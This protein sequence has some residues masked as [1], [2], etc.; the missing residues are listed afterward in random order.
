[1]TG[2]LIELAMA[3]GI[4]ALP[5]VVAAGLFAPGTRRAALALAPWVPVTALALVAGLYGRVVEMPWLLLGARVG[6]DALTAPLLLLAGVAWTL[7]GWHAHHHIDAVARKRFFLFWLLTWMGNLCVFITLDA[8]SFYAAYA[9]MTFAAYG[10]V[11]FHGRPQD[12]HAGGIYIIMA[13]LGEA[14]IIAALLTLGGSFGNIP[15]EQGGALVAQLPQPHWVTG[16]FLAGF[17]VKAGVVPLHMW[18]ALAH[19][20][21]PVPAS[22]V[23]SGVILKA[24]LM[25]WLRF[26]P[27][28]AE[29]FQVEGGVLAA[30]GLFT[31]FYGAAVSLPQTRAKTVLA[32]SSISQ[33][34]LIACAV[35]VALVFPGSAPAL[36]PVAVLFA[37]HHGLAKSA[38]FLSVD[39]AR[40]HPSMVRIAMWVPAVVLAGAPLTSGALA[41]VLFKSAVPAPWGWLNDALLASSVATTLI[42]ARFLALAWPRAAGEGEGNPLPWL[43]LVF[44]GL[45]LPWLIAVGLEPAAA[46]RPLHPE[47]LLEALWPLA[48]GIALVLAALRWWPRHVRPALPEGDII[49][50]FAGLLRL[51]RLKESAATVHLAG[52]APG[53]GRLAAAERTLKQLGPALTVLLGGL[54][55]LFL[56]AW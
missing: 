1:M 48:L 41:K 35:G 29:G 10:L 43:A 51:P 5:L 12:F 54:A 27:L 31:V 11:V 44:A 34:G 20:Q 18:L 14:M 21:A 45:G 6:V 33:M 23:L 36:L 17:A 47:Y 22:A 49:V 52:P 46:A 28:G 50:F 24:G 53:R 40:T 3:F 2:G 9:T 15:L 55:I 39:T 38:L 16:L 30:A 4:P 13:I 7:A 8:A 56:L 32:Y 42:M 25:G 19:P 37:L 26:L